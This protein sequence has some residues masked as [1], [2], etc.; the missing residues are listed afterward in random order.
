MQSRRR[1]TLGRNLLQVLSGPSCGH[2]V[3]DDQEQD[4]SGDVNEG[5]GS[6]RPVHESWSI[7]E[8]SLNWK[9]DEHMEALLEVDQLQCVSPRDI[10]GGIVEKQGGESAAKLINLEAMLEWHW[11]TAIHSEGRLTQ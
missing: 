5:I 7:E 4:R 8:P 3:H 2:V 1:S 9:L 10:D 11:C 6:V